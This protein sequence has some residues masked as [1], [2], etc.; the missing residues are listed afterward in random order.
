MSRVLVVANET[1][2]AEELLAEIRRDRG[3]PHVEVP[4]AGARRLPDQHGLGTWN[5]EGAIA[6]CAGRLDATLEL[7]RSEGLDATG[8]V[9]DM[10]PLAA[11]EDAL[12]TFPADMIVISTH[13]VARSRW[14]KK[15]LVEC[16]RKKFARP[17]R[18][19]GLARPRERDR[20]RSAIRRAPRA[21]GAPRRST[22]RDRS[23]P[24]CGC[25]PPGARDGRRHSRARRGSA[26]RPARP[27]RRA[28]RAASAR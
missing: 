16:A 2:G 1:V 10:V 12:V 19:R 5:Q 26:R 23:C 21:P 18:A 17:G 25:R 24:R 28:P 11:I 8:H 9:G 3:S 6:A 20:L 15:D 14:L 7:L 4:R 13:P 27:A 22:A